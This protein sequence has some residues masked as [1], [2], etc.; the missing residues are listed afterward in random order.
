MKS[1]TYKDI[2]QES[3]KR[4]RELRIREEQIFSGEILE[5]EALQH[6]FSENRDLILTAS[7]YMEQLLNFVKGT[8]F[9]ILLTDGQGCILN[10]IGDEKIL[11][12]AFELKMIPGA[13][14]SEESVGTNAM[15]MVIKTQEPIQLSGEDHFIKAY[16]K[17]TCSAS[18]IK[19]LENNLIGALNLT[20]YTE[21]V[22]P[23]TLGMVIAASN[24]I[25][26]MQKLKEYNTLEDIGNMHI[27]RVFNAI[28]VPVLT[29]DMKGKI[30]T[31]NAKAI[32][33]LSNDEKT[34]KTRDMN[35]IIEN[36]DK[37]YEKICVAKQTSMEISIRSLR[38]RYPCHLKAS[39]FLNVKEDTMEIVYVFDEVKKIKNKNEH[40]VYYTFDKIIG[41]A[42]NFEKIIQ[43]AKKIAD[44]KST[45]LLLGESGT[46]KEMF[47]QS[48]HNYSGRGDKAFIA[49]N[50]GAI[51]NQLIESEL[52]GYEDGAY[53]GAKKGGNVGKFELSNGGTI[54]LDEIGEMPLDMQIKL[55]RV[56]QEGVITRIGSQQSISVDVR[57]IAATNKDLKKE[58]ALGRFRKDLFYRLNVLP[59]YLPPLRQ[60]KEDIPLL[61]KYFM[62]NI[63]KN[64]DKKEVEISQE[65][66]DRL[67]N[68]NWPGNI[69]ELENVVELVIN[70]ETVPVDYFKQGEYDP[71]FEMNENSLDMDNTALDIDSME[72]KH[73]I[74]VLE[75]YKGNISHSAKAL[76]IRRNTLYNKIKKYDIKI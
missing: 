60:R 59:L 10:A 69:R 47:A 50:C 3:H 6:K 54:M 63:S 12:E 1:S 17:W 9:F 74:K 25:E 5:E 44:S 67:M 7:P 30:K 11:T 23:H 4:C 42:E 46:G 38:N 61:T 43:Y 58:V 8:N 65:N 26:E 14:M 53:T 13:N 33:V 49:L 19:D 2:I 71:V 55:L 48:I 75:R 21:S 29:S 70:T 40:Q 18:P 15:A 36:W 16:H 24:A 28:P 39:T 76:G 68:Y 56:L 45:I 27:K 34:L 57:V 41:K 66:L 51:P 32:E 52:F 72:K 64:L 22:H 31:Y 73:V 62:K 37:V 35:S 20:G